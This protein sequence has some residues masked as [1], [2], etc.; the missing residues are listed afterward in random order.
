MQIEFVSPDAALAPRT[1]LAIV[2]P[3]GEAAGG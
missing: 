3:E 2:V 1:L